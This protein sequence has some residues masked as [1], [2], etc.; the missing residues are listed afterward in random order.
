MAKMNQLWPL[1]LDVIKIQTS[2]FFLLKTWSSYKLGNP[3]TRVTHK[4]FT[5]SKIPFF[6]HF[7]LKKVGEDGG[8]GAEHYRQSEGRPEEALRR[9]NSGRPKSRTKNKRENKCGWGGGG[10]AHLP[11]PCRSPSHQDWSSASMSLRRL[12]WWPPSGRGSAAAE[13][14]RGSVS[15]SDILIWWR[16]SS[17]CL[18]GG[19]NLK[20]GGEILI[21]ATH[22]QALP[23]AFV[24]VRT[25]Y[26]VYRGVSPANVHGGLLGG[27]ANV[28]ADAAK[29]RAT[30]P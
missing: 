9:G 7:I 3:E 19:S 27:E 23:T 16:W 15:I 2:T 24:C 17:R 1:K 13:G 11:R 10:G 8:G 18:L 21:N 5:R 20:R 4:S 26:R 14:W 29:S 22:Q 6:H 30:W 12:G 25:I 28:N